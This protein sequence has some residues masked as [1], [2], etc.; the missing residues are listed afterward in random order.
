[1]ANLAAYWGK[2]RELM[3]GRPWT[4]WDHFMANTISRNKANC[5]LSTNAGL[6]SA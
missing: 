5:K 3:V 6:Y 4:D 1:M 2:V